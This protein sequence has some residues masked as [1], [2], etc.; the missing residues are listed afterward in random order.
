VYRGKT[1]VARQI[2]AQ[3]SRFAPLGR[4]AVVNGAAGVVVRMHNQVIAIA[5]LTVAGGLVVAIDLSTD[6]NKLG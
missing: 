3:G 2:L 1:A 6:P 4:P 5:G